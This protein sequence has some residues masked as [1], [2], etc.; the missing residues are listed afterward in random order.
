MR[1]SS[2]EANVNNLH[3]ELKADEEIKELFKVCNDPI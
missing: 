2:I 1:Y 3:N